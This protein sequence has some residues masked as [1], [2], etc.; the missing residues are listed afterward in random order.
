[1]RVHL[2]RGDHFGGV[3]LWEVGDEFDA[4]PLGSE[5]VLHVRRRMHEADLIALVEA[6]H[7]GLRERVRR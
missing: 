2:K 6:I 7:V 4:I 3:A 1:M 5:D